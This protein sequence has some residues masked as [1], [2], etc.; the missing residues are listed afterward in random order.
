VHTRIPK[1][2]QPI[3]TVNVY[4][5]REHRILAFD[6]MTHIGFAYRTNEGPVAYGSF[7]FKSKTPLKSI[8]QD[9]TIIEG[10][11]KKKRK[12][13]GRGLRW[14]R[15]REYLDTMMEEFDPTAI[16]FEAV[17]GFNPIANG[18]DARIY[19][20]FEAILT[21]WC[22]KRGIPY[23]PIPAGTIKKAETGRGDATKAMMIASVRAR[24]YEPQNDNVAD[25][26]ALL[27]Y[28]EKDQQERRAS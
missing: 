2:A 1:G 23:Y 22:E 19:W 21:G 9:V 8:E 12:N 5:I 13:E 25:A 14:R 16:Y 7:D 27:D 18:R 17:T 3:D 6:L 4:R 20:C 28:A 26:L 15:F 11:K 24:G 10:K